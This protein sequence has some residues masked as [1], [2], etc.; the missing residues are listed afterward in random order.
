MNKSLLITSL[1]IVMTGCLKSEPTV[2]V[3]SGL[4]CDETSDCPESFICSDNICL[5][6]AQCGDGVVQGWG[7]LR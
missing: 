3:T 4:S 5:D 1:V 7:I 6:L 2:Q